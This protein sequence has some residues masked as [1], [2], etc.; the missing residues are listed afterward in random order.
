M[1]RMMKI[2]KLLFIWNKI[3]TY[4]RTYS[5]DPLEYDDN[6]FQEKIHIDPSIAF[7]KLIKVGNIENVDCYL[8][9][10]VQEESF[11]YVLL[12]GLI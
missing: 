4:W 6:Y 8:S 3:G 11:F 2:E 1:I 10:D 9:T 5:V 7:S 12:L